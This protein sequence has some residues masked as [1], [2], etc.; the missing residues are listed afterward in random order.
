MKDRGERIKNKKS[1]T[2]AAVTRRVDG[3]AG[4]AAD[5]KAANLARR[6]LN[7]GARGNTGKATKLRDKAEKQD[8]RAMASL[9]SAEKAKKRQELQDH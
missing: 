9:S 6:A 1:G 5:N 3:E 8:S 2:V 7:A 4:Y